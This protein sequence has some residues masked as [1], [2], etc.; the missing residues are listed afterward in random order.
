MAHRQIVAKTLLNKAGVK[1]KK[2]YS[3]FCGEAFQVASHS[4][5]GVALLDPVVKLEMF[6]EMLC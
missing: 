1:S 2:K 6:L 3:T 5:L 4:M